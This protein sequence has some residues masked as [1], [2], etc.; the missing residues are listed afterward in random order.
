MPHVPKVAHLTWEFPSPTET[1]VANE[2]EALAQLGCGVKIIPLKPPSGTRRALALARSVVVRPITAV[3]LGLVCLKAGVPLRMLDALLLLE[4]RLDG[5][6]FDLVHAQFGYVG[7][8]CIPVLSWFGSLPLVVSFRGQDASALPRKH[9]GIYAPLL[10]RASAFLAR[11]EAMKRDLIAIGCP[12]GK[13]YVHHSGIDL[14]RFAFQERHAPPAESLPVRILLV[15]RL[16]EKKGVPDAIAAFAE[17]RRRRPNIQLRIIGD[18]P[19]REE[20][21]RNIAALGLADAVALLGHC[22]HDDVASEM[23]A[24]HLF[25]LPCRTASDGDKEGI[26]NAIMEAMASG[27]PVLSTRHAGIPECVEDGVSGLLVHE[28]DT[29]ALADRLCRLLDHPDLWPGMGRAGRAKIEDE[30][31]RDTQ[32]QRLLSVYEQV[33]P[34]SCSPSS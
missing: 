12:A 9:P 10:R 23:A 19:M 28:G 33:I 22:P 21:L 29:A 27:L 31:N 25:M 30:F 14:D 5:E 4:R 34:L 20:I 7:H 18:G 17:A 16:I 26:P 15:G 11:S 6:S 8:L 3:R 32:A 2:V 24:A 13:T 1:F